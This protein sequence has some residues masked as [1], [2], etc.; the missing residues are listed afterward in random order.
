MNRRYAGLANPHPNP[1]PIAVWRAAF[2][3]AARNYARARLETSTR[4][5]HIERAAA[6]NAARL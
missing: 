5:R 2:Q 3:A 6:W 4:H 1:L